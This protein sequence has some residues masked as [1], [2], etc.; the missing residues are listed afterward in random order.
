MSCQR[1]PSSPLSSRY[2]VGLQ[3]QL[4]GQHFVVTVLCL[5]HG[6]V[7]LRQFECQRFILADKYVALYALGSCRLA[8]DHTPAGCIFRAGRL[9]ENK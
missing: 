9:I 7:D 4:P 3:R 8:G 1:R 5:V 2:I 6:I